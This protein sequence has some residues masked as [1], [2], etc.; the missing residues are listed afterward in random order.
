MQTS[1]DCAC[2]RPRNHETRQKLCGAVRWYRAAV[3]QRLW[4]RRPIFG[5]PGSIPG[6]DTSFDVPESSCL[7]SG[8]GLQLDSRYTGRRGWFGGSSGMPSAGEEESVTGTLQHV[9]SSVARS[10][11]VVL[12]GQAV[13]VQDVN[14]RRPGFDPRS[15]HIF[16]RPWIFLSSLWPRTPTWFPLQCSSAGWHTNESLCTISKERTQRALKI[17]R[18]FHHFSTTRAYL[19]ENHERERGPIVAQSCQLY[20]HVLATIGPVWLSRSDYHSN[21]AANVDLPVVWIA[22]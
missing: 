9:K 6:R 5:D 2:K 21:H 4:C 19:A 3:V 10:G 22:Y 14:S 15:R 16:W 18:F 8:P 7:L 20:R 11:G 1:H 17:L 13:M 12:R